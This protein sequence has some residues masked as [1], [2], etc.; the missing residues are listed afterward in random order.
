MGKVIK[1][2]QVGQQIGFPTANLDIQ[3]PYKLYPEGGV[4]AV[5]IH[6]RAKDYMGM[7]N[8]GF[9]PTRNGDSKTVEVNIFDFNDEIYGEELKLTF[10]EQI[11][12]ERKFDNLESLKN[13]LI[14]DREKVLKMVNQ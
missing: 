5:Q 10:L 8:I 14:L 7:L 13:Q 6:W 3:D 2:D 9:R 12:K 4:Y 11:R 1:G